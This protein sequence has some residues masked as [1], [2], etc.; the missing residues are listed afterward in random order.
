[1]QDDTDAPQDSTPT[2]V[3]TTESAEF[4]AHSTYY[5]S[6]NYG[7]RSP[8]S[9]GGNILMA[10]SILIG[11][12]VTG[13]TFQLADTSSASSSAL[14]GEVHV[15]D[16]DGTTKL[17]TWT[18][19][20]TYNDLGGTGSPTTVEFSG[21][22]VVGEEWMTFRYYAIDEGSHNIKAMQ[23]YVSGGSHATTH[24]MQYL[25]YGS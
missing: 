25:A 16:T 1:M 11:K 6:A 24:H 8:T 21:D 7:S 23:R 15:Y 22:A 3:T 10:D 12:E 5:D 4:D 13:I 18:T 20:T 17:E 2:D 19:T 9:W 14:A